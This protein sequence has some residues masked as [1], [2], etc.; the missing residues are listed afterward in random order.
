MQSKEAVSL[1]CLYKFLQQVVYKS[2]EVEILHSAILD[3]L[4]FDSARLQYFCARLFR[5]GFSIFD[6]VFNECLEAFICLPESE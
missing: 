4:F 3:E 1:M 5:H 2:V 6:V